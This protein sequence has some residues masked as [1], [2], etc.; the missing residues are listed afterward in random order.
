[1]PK[2]NKKAKQLPNIV[3]FLVEGDSDQI[4]LELPLAGMITEKYPDYEVRFLR[5]RQI[6]GVFLTGR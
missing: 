1:M 2:K 3:V 4:A 6:G 5:K